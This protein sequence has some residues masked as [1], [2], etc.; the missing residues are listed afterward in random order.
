M[1]IL[2]YKKCEWGS[3]VTKLFSVIYPD[4][5]LSNCARMAYDENHPLHILT[6]VAVSGGSPIGQINVFSV[7]ES[8]KLGNVGYHVHPDWQRKGVASRLLAEVLPR[9]AGTFKDGLVV[10]CHESNLA[11]QAL[12]VKF[13]FKPASDTLVACYRHYLKLLNDDGVCFHLSNL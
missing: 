11:S 1:N 3:A 13:D 5:P 8:A 10:Q 12:A 7:G 2:E 4:W 6:L 9:V